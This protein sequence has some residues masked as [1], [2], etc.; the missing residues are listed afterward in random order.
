MINTYKTHS[1]IRPHRNNTNADGYRK[2]KGF[3]L[4]LVMVTVAI[5][6]VLGIGLAYSQSIRM[7]SS[8]NLMTASQMRYLAES[9]LNHGLY[10]LWVDPWAYNS[11]NA[12]GPFN[13]DD[14]N[15]TY[16]IWA[17][18]DPIEQGVYTIFSRATDGQISQTVSLK[19]FRTI[20]YK[21]SLIAKGPAGYWRLGESDGGDALDSSGNGY[22][23]TAY[24]GLERNEP[25][26]ITGDADYAAD[27]DGD[28]YLYRPPTMALKIGGNFT[29][30]LWFQIDDYPDDLAYLVTYSEEG[31]SPTANAMYEIVLT[32]EG[33]I[34]FLMEYGNGKDITNTFTGLG[35]TPDTWH[36]L[37]VT[38][39]QFTHTVLVYVDGHLAGS[40]NYTDPGP[41]HANSG[42]NSGLYIGS[43][44]GSSNFFDGLMDD[45]SI[46]GKTLSPGELEYLYQAATT[47][48]Y[49]EVLQW[50]D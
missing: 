19:A 37:A 50:G 1:M 5:A 15:G 34:T 12:I 21:D 10:I 30:S 6:V 20:P 39:N 41:P 29:A 11:G 27:F 43:A 24:G 18:K 4:L 31:D 44:Y 40:W 14:T 47:G 48:Q 8:R 36:N 49:I 13:L 42:K 3:A 7:L 35:I 33:N 16:E 32:P 46:F 9:G 17:E 28:D 2:C 38:R 26:A 22:N 23:L 25:G 45:L